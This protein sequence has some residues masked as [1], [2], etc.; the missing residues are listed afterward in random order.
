[1]TPPQDE[2]VGSVGDEAAKLLGALADWAG[3]HVNGRFGDRVREVNDHIAT[4]D[5]ECLYCPICRT[6]HAVR[7]A[8]PEV[9]AQLTQAA[10]TFLQAAA[11]L[12]SAAGA[13]ESPSTRVQHI[14]LD[15]DSP[16]DRDPG[17]P[18]D[19]DPGEDVP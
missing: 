9:K 14:D 18:D 16:D 15:A 19:R 10:T 11:G 13:A 8:S 4:G 2:P 6:V 5:A 3:D 12:L 7:E 17:A 1:M